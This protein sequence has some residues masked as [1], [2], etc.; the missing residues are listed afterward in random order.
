MILMRTSALILFVL[1]F[2]IPAAV[3]AAEFRAGD[4][5]NIDEPIDDDLFAT[6]AEITVNAPVRSITAAG[7][8]I[9]I[10]APVHG[11]VIAA[12]GLITINAVID[13]KV[14]AAGGEIAIDDTIGTNVILAG[15]RVDLKEN[16]K[17]TR[18]AVINAGT[19]KNAGTVGGTLQV[20]AEEFENTGTAG[21]VIFRQQEEEDDGGIS[22]L[23]ILVSIGFL[24]LG[25]ILIRFVPAPFF[26]VRQE[27]LQDPVRTTLIGFGALILGAVLLLLLAITIIGLPTALLLGMFLVVAILLASLFVSSAFG[28]AIARRAGWTIG[29]MGAFVMGFILLHLIFLIPVAGII[30]RIIVVSM[31]FGALL[32]ALSTYRDTLFPQEGKTGEGFEKEREEET[33]EE[34]REG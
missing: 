10:D 22:I 18:D 12:G 23:N 11:D 26:A 3:N 9:T 16:A 21:E 5:I 34:G 7:G 27:V 13:G 2:L 4:T 17:I 15:G 33:G 20:T 8:M 29:S 24:I 31:G 19:A 6:G 28:T 14:I 25:L 30:T 1:L 32:V